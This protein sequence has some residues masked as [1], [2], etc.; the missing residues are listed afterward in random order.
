MGSCLF[1]CADVADR[2]GV[3]VCASSTPSDDDA[4]PAST[5]ALLGLIYQAPIS[6]MT[7]YERYNKTCNI[8]AQVLLLTVCRKLHGGGGLFGCS[9]MP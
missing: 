6:C 8:N 3:E 1:R 2:S 4:D 7:G 5:T 9:T